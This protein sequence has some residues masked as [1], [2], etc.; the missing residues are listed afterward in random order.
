MF[1]CCATGQAARDPRVDPDTGLIRTLFMGDAYMASG[2]VTPLIVKDPMVVL[3][4]LPVEFITL[5]Y[6][7][8]DA[9]ARV[10]RTYFPRTQSQLEGSYD[11]LIMAE[12]R[13]PFVPP[14]YQNWIKE[15]V[16]DEGIGFLMGGGAQS[17]GGYQAWNHPS[18]DGSP[19]GDIIAVKCI[20]GW[21]LGTCHVVPD[22][23]HEDHPIVRNIPWNQILI[24]KRNRA[25]ERQGTV[26]IARSDRN[27]PGAPIFAYR[28]VGRGISEAFTWNWGGDGAQ[29]FHRWDYAPIV[30]SNLIYYAAGVEIPVDME[31][32]LRLRK[33][34]SSFMALRKYAISVIDFADRFNANT[35]EAEEILFDVDQD[36]KALISLYVNGDFEGSLEKLKGSLDDL[37]RVTQI[38]IKAKN[39]A[40][41]WV[42]V[43]EWLSVSGTAMFAGAVLWTLMVRRTAYREVVTT[44][45]I[46]SGGV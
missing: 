19:I 45:L 28:E 41:L 14:K 7:S 4:P 17:F 25:M 27:P 10:M 3:N 16:I 42:Y 43:I 20:E 34:L 33:M 6:M 1:L 24:H 22:P 15:G 38:A 9:A 30:M 37:G 18:W 44:R 5:E 29:D 39:D 12:V 46:R 35:R 40:L 32:F 11:V 2:F 13:E 21:N 26:V 36:R 8:I 31:V 23:M